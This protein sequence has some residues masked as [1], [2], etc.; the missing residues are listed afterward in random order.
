LEPAYP[1]SLDVYKTASPRLQGDRKLPFVRVFVTAG[2]LA[3]VAALGGSARGSNAGQ[4]IAATPAWSPDGTHIAFA[5]GTLGGDRGD[6]YTVARD[7]TE[8]VNLT[9]ADDE[10]NHLFPAWSHDGGLVASTT[11]LGGP[12]DNH[13]IYSVT[14]SDG[15]TT[16]HIA[17]STAVGPTSWSYDDRWI[18]FDARESALVARADGSGQHEVAAPACC[19]VWAPH[20]LRLLVDRTHAAGDGSDIYLVTP[21]GQVLRR[22]TRPP[23]HRVRGA[24]LNTNNTPVAWSRDGRPSCSGVPAP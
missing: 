23:M 18:A 24:P 14:M 7:G 2:L 8:L 6:V 12:N 5:G 3:A 11:A 13:E 22:L 17:T 21:V 15:G 20:G 16:A 10:P 9:A 1:L 4:L 19:A